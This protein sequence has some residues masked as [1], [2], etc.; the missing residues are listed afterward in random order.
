MQVRDVPAPAAAAGPSLR[1]TA[2]AQSWI[3]VADAKGQVVLS[4]VLQEG[5]QQEFS[6]AAPY[7]IRVGNVRGTQVEWR[8]AAVDLAAQGSN[9]VA[10]L[11]LN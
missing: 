10:R 5:E 1:I 9:N 4:R 8:G 2:S 11:E 7:K 6:G 3:E